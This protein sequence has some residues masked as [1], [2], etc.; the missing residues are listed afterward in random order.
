MSIRDFYGVG[1]LA[2]MAVGWDHN[3]L[4]HHFRERPLTY[5]Q[6]PKMNTR[7]IHKICCYQLA[8]SAMRWALVWI[9]NSQE[10]LLFSFLVVIRCQSI[11]TLSLNQSK[12][13]PCIVWLVNSFV[14][15]FR[16]MM[17][18][19]NRSIPIALV[20]LSIVCLPRYLLWLNGAGY[21]AY[22][23]LPPSD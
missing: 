9:S 3:R 15:L 12:R 2:Q 11:R 22:V 13:A 17:L 8:W 21:D 10:H 4:T 1:T 23:V 5:Y 20:C 16:P 18:S 14:R 7:L 19:H 6:R